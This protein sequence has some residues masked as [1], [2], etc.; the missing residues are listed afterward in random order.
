M[1]VPVSEPLLVEEGVEEEPEEAEEEESEDNEE[2]GEL[3]LLPVADPLDPVE[4]E[5]DVAVAVP[6]PPEAWT[7]SPPSPGRTMIWRRP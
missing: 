1:P 2:D 6:F 5:E 4:E 3:E 7:G